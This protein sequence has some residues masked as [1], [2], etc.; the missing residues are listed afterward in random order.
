LLLN[1]NSAIF[2]AIAWREQVN[3]K[4]NDDE[5]RFVLDQ[6]ALLDFCSASSLKQQSYKQATHIAY[7]PISHFVLNILYTNR[8]GGVVVSVLASREVDRG[9][10]PRSG[11][12]K[13]CKIGICCF[14]AKH[15]ALRRKSK[16]WLARNQDNVPE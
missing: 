8:I 12:T 11:Q 1:V 3:F 16:D 4:R 14:S 10:D 2:P 7:R 13:D 15:V 9:F 5:V 6:H